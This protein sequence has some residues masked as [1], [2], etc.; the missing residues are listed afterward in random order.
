MSSLL[1][2]SRLILRPLK[3][4]PVRTALTV[5]AVALGVAVVVAI[6]LAG[7]AAAGSFH[8]SIESLTG[9]SDLLLTA[10]G[11][12]DETLL[13]ALT[14]LSYPLD[15]AP[16]IEDFAS[17]DGKGEAIP[18]IGVDLI[19]HRAVQ[20]DQQDPVQPAMLLS[21]PNP[22]WVGSMLHLEPGTVVHLLIND[23][24]RSYTVAGVLKSEG[25]QIGE[26]NIVIADIG[27]AQFVTG[28]TGKL[29]S[30]DVVVPETRSADDW[31]KVIAMHVPASV[32]VE[33]RGAR[34]D[35]NR[36]MLSAFRWNLRVLSY[37]A[38]VVG[39][40]L[41][42]NTIS[43]SVV[44][45][46]NEIGVLRALG[47]TRL[48]IGL[49]FL[50]ESLFF[51]LTGSLFGLLLGR[52]MAVGAVALIGKTV[53]SLYVSSEPSPI[54]L[55]PAGAL[56]GVALGIAI[57]LLGA[58]APASEAAHVAPVEAMARGR[59]EYN[60]AVRSRTRIW[61]AVGMLAVGAALA[62]LPAIN[63][64]PLA[65]YASVLLLVAG[66]STAVPTIITFF[67]HYA[68]RPL[69]KL[70]GTE[71]GLALRSLRASLGRTSVLTAALTVAVAMTTSVGI[72]VGSFRETVAVWM[73]N[74]LKADF[75]LRPA[76]S[77]SADRHPTMSGIADR[78]AEL[79]GVAG[80]DRFRAYPISYQGLPATL[81]G[82]ESTTS[83]HFLPGENGAAIL[84]T[85]PTGDFAVVSEPFANK[86][87]IHAGSAITL[88]L[89]GA[90]R[91]F[92][93]LG[94]YYD[95]STER[96]YVILA[97]RT[98]LRY[99][100]D[101]GASNLAV[102]LKRGAD[103]AAVRQAIGRIVAG[104]AVLIFANRTLRRGAIEIFDRTF[105]IT[106]ALEAVAISVAVM[107]IAGALLAMVIDRRREF[108]ILRFLGAAQPQVRNIILFEAAL[109]G[110]L[111]NVIGLIL[112]ALLSLLLI[113]VINKQ[114]FGW[115]FQFHWPVTILLAALTVVYLATV[116]A[117][118]YPARTALRMNPIEVV[119]EA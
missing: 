51:A 57:S 25:G 95:Y 12:I 38:L 2:F 10:T 43:V 56:T 33:P 111:A 66:A 85:L 34:T 14:Q 119:H 42:Y 18:F 1:L 41:I 96:G 20:L 107:G 108:A 71:A 13:A 104:R 77:S 84:R 65:A 64:K 93:V 83:T 74:Q 94:I 6:D 72:M 58:L 27:L 98:L 28:K 67:A 5:F 81:A 79:P 11:G 37:I 39:A 17:I 55:T 32:M 44:R 75:Y 112:G 16:R 35:E 88:P 24:L 46:R 106:Y 26:Q 116:L 9:K 73:D 4:E 70:L 103:P 92:K 52:V 50:A 60:A 82:G 68:A 90:H 76:G 7:Q 80:V 21:A 91:T 48:F 89:A 99:L 31:R 97:R 102:N 63:G 45:R 8:S 105:R 59:E 54:H 100:P 49:G 101:P 19:G 61:W 40:F 53:Q 62:Q 115:T 3:C 47:A 114:S 86:H 118:L 30:I 113:F 109:L 29:D 78:I 22:I 15:F 69:Q 87:N 117:G 110:L 23:V 36:K